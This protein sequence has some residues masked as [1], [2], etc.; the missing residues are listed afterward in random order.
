M[1]VIDNINSSCG[2]R[3]FK[4]KYIISSCGKIIL[5]KINRFP[6]FYRYCFEGCQKIIRHTFIHW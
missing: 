3:Y 2:T 1:I 4:I 5:K 6:L